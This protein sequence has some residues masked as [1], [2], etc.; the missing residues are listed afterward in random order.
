MNTNNQKF[1]LPKEKK[2]KNPFPALA[3]CYLLG[4]C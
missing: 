3:D 1:L 2:S 4:T